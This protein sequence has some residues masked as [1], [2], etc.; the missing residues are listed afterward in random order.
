MG[1]FFDDINNIMFDYDG[2]GKVDFW[3]DALRS[4]QKKLITGHSKSSGPSYHSSN[5]NRN[6]VFDGTIPSK[7]QQKEEML[8]RIRSRRAK[9]TAHVAEDNTDK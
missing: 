1:D 5:S 7:K 8:E 9:I 4:S 3:D 2:N 6:I